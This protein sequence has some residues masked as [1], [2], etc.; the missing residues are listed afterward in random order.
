M[1]LIIKLLQIL[2]CSLV[3]RVAYKY[4]NK[5]RVRKLRKSEEEVLDESIVQ[6]VV[7][8]SFTICKYQWGIENNKTA[9]LVHGW[10]GRA[11]NFASIIKNLTNNGYK[12]IAYDAPSHGKSS[13][14]DTNM[15]EFSEL[16]ESELNKFIPDLI[17]SHSFGS[18]NTATVL[19]KNPNLKINLW[20]MVTT[21]YKFIEKINDLSEYFGLNSKVKNKLINRIQKDTQESINQL[22]MAIY[23]DELKNV[24]KAIIVHSKTDKILPIEGAR[25]VAKSFRESKLIELNN[26]GHYAILWSNEL[27]EIIKN[28][29]VNVNTVKV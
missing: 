5:P 20:L 29:I 28:E 12:V 27:N 21:P 9:L 4:M 19:R 18:V 1:K 6:K 14:G 23:C 15:F 26:L 3:S 22:D 10:E 16:L 2:S 11:S 8:N 17:I 13:K 7:Y 24:E 25:K